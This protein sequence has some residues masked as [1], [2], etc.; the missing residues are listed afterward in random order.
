[1][2]V[3]HLHTT[4]I[5]HL[6]TIDGPTVAA[7]SELN[8]FAHT[9]NTPT[10]PHPHSHPPPHIQVSYNT[11]AANRATA[12]LVDTGIGGAQNPHNADLAPPGDRCV[13]AVVGWPAWK[14]ACCVV[15]LSHPGTPTSSSRYV[16]Q[17][18]LWPAW[19]CACCVVG[20]S[21]PGTPTSSPSRTGDR[22]VCAVVGHVGRTS[23]TCRD[24]PL[25]YSSR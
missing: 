18:R 12:R 7:A 17:V 23:H 3:C 4:I 21:H 9:H 24:T 8:H 10:H 11:A 15:G 19:K 6:K 14:C 5:A 1:M 22:C 13:C 25:I 16:G 2:S 20:L